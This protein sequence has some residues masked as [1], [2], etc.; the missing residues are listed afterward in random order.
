M[1]RERER[2]REYLFVGVIL[3][4]LLLYGCVSR[5]LTSVWVCF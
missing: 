2:E 1:E 5:G 3:E 4:G